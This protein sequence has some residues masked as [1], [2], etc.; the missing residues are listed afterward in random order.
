MEFKWHPNDDPPIIEEHSRV[1]LE[2]LRKYLRGYFDTLNKNPI[3][4]E[5]KIDLVDGFA[6]GGTFRDGDRIIPG[7]PLIM[8]DESRNAQER[9]NKNRAKPLHFD[10]RYYFY[11]IESAHTDHLKKT[12]VERGY[13]F[14]EDNLVIQ[15]AAFEDVVEKTINNIKKRQPRAGRAI[16]LLDQT[17]YKQVSLM[18]ANK[19]FSE[20]PNAEIILTFAVDTL[21]NLLNNNPNYIKS[22]APLN[23][24]DAQIIEWLAMKN[25]D[26]GKALIQRTLRKHIRNEVGAKYDTPFF[27][28]PQSSRRALWFLHL[29]R[30]PTARNV[31][32]EQHWALENK[33]EHF[34]RSDIDILGWDA[35]KP[36]QM[37]LLNFNSID[38]KFLMNQ[39]PDSII[40]EIYPLAYDN[41]ITVGAFRHVISNRTAATNEFVDQALCTLHNEKELEILDPQ[42][43][44]RQKSY[45]NLKPTDQ[46]VV[47]RQMLFPGLSRLERKK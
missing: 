9:L 28:R 21:I 10:C 47:P 1:K 37:P 19:I 8:I 43:I 45:Q 20:L 25:G 36:G 46:I 13:E 26:G 31:M 32:L 12:I 22:T 4:D 29:S 41:S 44:P 11:D 42:N 16:F 14:T 23:I 27:I 15:N 18:H 6:G 35:I 40:R 17:G 24:S 2:V 30:H 7:S 39:L 34:G 33:F 3:R 38:A 5:F